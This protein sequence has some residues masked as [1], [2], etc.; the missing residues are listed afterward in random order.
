MEVPCCRG[1]LKIV[2]DAREKAH[3]ALP[4]KVLTVGIKD[5]SVLKEEMV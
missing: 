3:R 5:G 2:L 4:V 1:L